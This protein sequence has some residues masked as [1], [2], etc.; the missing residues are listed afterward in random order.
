MDGEGVTSVE[1]DTPEPPDERDVLEAWLQ[2]R[3]VAF[4][5]ERAKKPMSSYGV[6]G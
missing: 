5:A 2:G 3:K 6:E 4:F 1:P